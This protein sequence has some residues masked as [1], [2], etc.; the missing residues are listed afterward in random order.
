MPEI[1]TILRRPAVEAAVGLRRSA[2]YDLI[3]QGRFPRPVRLTGKAV[4]WRRSEV[5][6]WL[7][8]LTD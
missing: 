2:L 1:E 3:K 8:A 6:A 4:G 5:V 7:N